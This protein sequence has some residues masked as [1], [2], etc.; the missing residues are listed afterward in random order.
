MPLI[1]GSSRKAISENIRRERAAGKPQNQ[2]IAIAM[3]VAARAKRAAGGAVHVGPLI[4]KVAGR[5]D[6]R[7]IHVPEGAYVLPADHVSS[8]GEGNTLNGFAILAKMFGDGSY[9]VEPDQKRAKGG[10]AGDGKTVPIMAAD[11][12]YVISPEAINAKWGDLKSG[13][14][15]LDQWVLEN[16][17]KHVKTLQKL[18][19]PA[20][21]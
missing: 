17:K 16:R 11:G 19:G 13:H 12:E 5:T 4:G 2:A 7:P 1:K 20:K 9:G 10:A 14:A 3:N 8:L 21:T 18:P 6:H 15:E